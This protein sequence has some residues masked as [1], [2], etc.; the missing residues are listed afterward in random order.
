MNMSPIEELITVPHEA[1]F[2]LELWYALVNQA[3]RHEPYKLESEARHAKHTAFCELVS[4]D[5][6]DNAANAIK[7][8]TSLSGN[9]ATTQGAD[10][11]SDDDTGVPEEFY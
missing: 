6:H 1:H 4:H 5:R 11:S 8:R 7:H 9:A 2:R 3:Y 10:S